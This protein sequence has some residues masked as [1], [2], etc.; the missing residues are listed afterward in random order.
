MEPMETVWSEW[1]GGA[2]ERLERANRLLLERGLWKESAVA[3]SP[4]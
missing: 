1:V 4:H 3:P 2:I